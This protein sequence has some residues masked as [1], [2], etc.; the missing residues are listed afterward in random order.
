MTQLSPT[1]QKAYDG[2][3]AGCKI[4]P[5]ISL[6][7]S[8]GSGRTTVLRTL[9][10]AVGGTFVTI[11][12]WI[13][14]MQE[15]H[16]LPME[17]AFSRALF[18]AL[19]EADTIIVDDLHLLTNVVGSYCNQAYP[20]QGY[21]EAVLTAVMAYA[22]EA[23][24][25]IVIGSQGA[26]P[27]AF[28]SRAYSWGITDYTTE[29]Y[30]FLCRAY[31]PQELADRLDFGRIFRFAPHLNAHQLRGACLWLREKQWEDQ[32]GLDTER[33]VD[34]LRSQH[35]TSNVDLQEVQQVR[36]EDL[37]G[38]EDVIRSLEANIVLPLEND[39]L[40][41]ELDLKPKR[42][43]LLAGPPGTGKTTV[44]RALAH[45]LKSKFFLI[46]GT[47][48]SGTSNFYGQISHIFQAATE[49]APSII[50]IDDSDVIFES[51]EES[52]LYRY[53]L[54]M[55]DG[56]ESENVGQV[57]VMLTAM[58]VGT[59][60]PALMRS[61]RVELWLE[62]SLPDDNARREIL[63]A[64]VGK[65]PATVGAVDL[66]PLVAAT[67]GF[68]GADLK[69]LMEDGK[70]LLAHDR[71]LEKPAR[72]ATEYFLEAV[73]S[74]V[75]SRRRYAAAAARTK[76]QHPDRPPWFSGFAQ[77]DEVSD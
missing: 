51:G 61:G 20:R 17:E 5:F 44:G 66:E 40:S 16:P 26:V 48:I 42:G 71:V 36:L 52:G 54:T 57:C 67:D 4:G 18:A 46:D 70:L 45:R 69:R 41:V 1:Q 49:N 21:L 68:T 6:W 35:L 30:A 14:R 7:A 19:A 10:S 13:D 58:D 53:L 50:F 43:V 73:K 39:A 2:L 75:E 65:F 76:A 64:I 24:K 25:R 72:P 28:S 32:R 8:S 27:D 12:E 63:G 47:I 74:V 31:L 9:H 38:V 55:L 23:G 11:R 60:P 3:S 29:D 34:Y 33:F 37:R 77:P 59:L 15:Q 56:L 62:M 22:T